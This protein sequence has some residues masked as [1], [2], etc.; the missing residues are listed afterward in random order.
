MFTMKQKCLRPDF[1]SLLFQA[2]HSLLTYV[3]QRLM[4]P[5]GCFNIGSEITSARVMR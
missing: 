1:S 4:L 2:N 3:L 5:R